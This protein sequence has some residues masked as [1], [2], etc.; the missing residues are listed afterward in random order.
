LKRRCGAI[1]IGGDFGKVSCD[2]LR[3]RSEERIREGDQITMMRCVEFNPG[4]ACGAVHKKPETNDLDSGSLMIHLELHAFFSNRSSF[5]QIE[6]ILI[7]CLKEVQCRIA[8]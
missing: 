4:T 2:K 3:R 1:A 6:T 5:F 8:E 7:F